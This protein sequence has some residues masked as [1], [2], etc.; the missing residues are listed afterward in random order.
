[1]A[2]DVSTHPLC[3]PLH[4]VVKLIAVSMKTKDF[5]ASVIQWDTR[6]LFAIGEETLSSFV[7]A[8]SIIKTQI[9]RSMYVPSPFNKYQEFQSG[10]G[11]YADM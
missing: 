3:S 6:D 2:L 11:I 10:C 7:Q 5:E 8:E 9:I 1:M 4:T